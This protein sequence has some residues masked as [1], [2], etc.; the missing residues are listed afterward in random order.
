MASEVKGFD[1]AKG[2]GRSVAQ[3]EK[4]KDPPPPAADASLIEQMAH[5]AATHNGRARYK[6]RQQTV[7]PVFG[8]IKQAL[9][10]RRFSLRG[11]AK[12]SL[13]WKLVTLAYNLK[14]LFI[15]G[16]RLSAA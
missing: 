7:E 5:R 12:A 13:E 16:A 11:Q 4:K 14:R 2:H 1:N 9:G 15:L 3:L 10:F 8:I 6:L